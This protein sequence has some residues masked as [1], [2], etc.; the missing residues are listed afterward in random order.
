MEMPEDQAVVHC[1]G[2]GRTKGKVDF[3]QKYKE[4]PMEVEGWT[5]V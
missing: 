3:I 2:L 4:N 1:G 5:H